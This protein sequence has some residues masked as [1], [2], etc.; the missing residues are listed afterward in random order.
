MTVHGMLR[1]GSALAACAL[2][3]AALPGL[4]AGSKKTEAELKA[5]NQKIDLMTQ[6]V[7]RDAVERE[8]QS[9]ALRAAEISL[10]QARGE[11]ARLSQE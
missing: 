6:R 2:L 10:G 7:S 11:L 8:R 9:A 5:L 3:A 1:M 4:A